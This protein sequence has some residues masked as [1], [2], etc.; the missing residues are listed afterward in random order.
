MPISIPSAPK[1]NA[2]APLW[3]STIPPAA[4]TGILTAA[5]TC[6]TKAIVDSKE[7][8]PPPSQPLTTTKSAPAFSAVT[9]SAK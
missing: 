8:W 6:G 4:T 5:T 7:T 3:P 2:A 9:A 1:A